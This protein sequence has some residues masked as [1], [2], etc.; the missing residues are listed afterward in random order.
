MET[1]TS[2]SNPLVARVR[3][4]TRAR[5]RERTHLLLDGARLVADALR[6]GVEVE[7]V[8]VSGAALESDDPP[9]AALVQACAVSRVALVAAGERVLAAIS[10]SR[11]PSRAVALAAHHPVAL[12]ALLG[13]A[14]VSKGCV[15]AAAGVQDPGNVGAII[16]AAD[17]AG[18]TGV[19]VSAASADPF[20]DK[21]LRGAM[22][23]T[24]RIPVAD[25][26]ETGDLAARAAR[27]GCRVVA[28][29]PRGG[30]SIYAI[31]LRQPTVVLIG[32]E[33]AGID[34]AVADAAEATVSIP[35]ANG[36]ESLNAAVAAALIAYEARRQRVT[37][38]AAPTPIGVSTR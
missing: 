23:S 22:G 14:V 6:S 35:M 37:T 32:G 10:Q 34:P 8:V 26:G 36:V 11:S 18:A 25:A 29:I 5:R 15:L 3:A 28:A 30:E 7:T 16:R 4:A 24:F 33:G 21:A 9:V 31:D 19:I 2:R 13:R 38:G 1:I 20:G 27:A 12:E 17:A